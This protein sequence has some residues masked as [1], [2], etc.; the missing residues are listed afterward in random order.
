MISK[1]SH[2][3]RKDEEDARPPPVPRTQRPRTKKKIEKKKKSLNHQ[4]KEQQ[5]EHV[6]FL[7]TDAH[8]CEKLNPNSWLPETLQAEI[9]TTIP[10]ITSNGN[11]TEVLRGLAQ[12]EIDKHYPAASWTHIYTDGSAENAT[13]N[14]GCG[15]YIKRPGKPLLSVLAP[16]GIQYSNYRAEVLALP[17]ATETII[18]WEEK[19]KKGVFLTY[20]LS[21]LQALMSREPDTTQKKLTENISTLAQTTC[22]ILQRIPAHTGTGGNETADQLARK[23]RKGKGAAP[24]TSVLK[25][26]QNSYP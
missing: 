1:T 12:E 3:C 8:L 7:T 23:G 20:A 6:D 26:S 11:Q 14:G 16:G 4:R 22:I 13:R 15:A 25:R 9:R 10:G 18:P 17:N 2:P 21:A 24:I 5:K 19:P